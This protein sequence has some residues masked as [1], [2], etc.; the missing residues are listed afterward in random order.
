MHLNLRK[1]VTIRFP[2][3]SPTLC[4]HHTTTKRIEAA[5]PH[6][7]VN[8]AYDGAPPC[9]QNSVSPTNRTF[10]VQRRRRPTFKT[11][12]MGEILPREKNSTTAV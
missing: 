9:Y 7:H 12:P 11:N 6:S 3:P 1:H 5:I 8:Q 10:S 2:S 4:P